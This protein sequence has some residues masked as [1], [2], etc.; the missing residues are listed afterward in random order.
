MGVDAQQ[1]VLDDHQAVVAGDIECRPPT[2]GQCGL[3]G[4]R[5]HVPVREGVSELLHPFRILE[6]PIGGSGPDPIGDAR[7]QRREV[8]RG[9]AGVER[10]AAQLVDRRRQ[11]PAHGTPPPSTGSV[12]RCRAARVR[13]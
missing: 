12:D 5:S 2:T 7:V 3:P 1:Q 13:R 11:H 4:P 9:V 6:P 10:N 8:P